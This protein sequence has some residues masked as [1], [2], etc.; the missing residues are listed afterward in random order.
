MNKFFKFI[1][2]VILLFA[3]LL[4]GCGTVTSV[5][6]SAVGPTS[7]SIAEPITQT[8]SN[9][10]GSPTSSAAVTSTSAV[11][12]V[13][14]IPVTSTATTLTSSFPV[15]TSLP[16]VPA[17]YQ[18]LYNQLQGYVTNNINQITLQWDDSTY[19]VNYSSELIT[20]DTNAGPG[21]LQSSQQQ[22]MIEELNGDAAMGVKSVTVE[23][24]CPVFD[25]NFYIFSGQTAAQAQQTVQSWLGYYQSLAQAVHN[26]GLKMI[27]ESNPLLT[28]Y[29]SSQS[30]F[31]PGLYYKTLSFAAYE[32][33]RSQHNIIIAQQIKPDYLILQTEPQTD[34]VNDFRPELNNA[35][36]D[37][38]MIKSFVNDLNN[39]GISGLHASIF[40]GSGAGTWQPDWKSYFTG[41]V[42]ISGLD[43][44]DT[45]IY[46]LQPGV[47]KIGEVTIAGQ[48][49]DMA[50]AAGKGVTMSEFWFH[51]SSTLVGLT[52]NG[53]S[54]TDL[55]V[56]DMFSFWA[57]LDAQAF[58]LLSDL[59]NYKHFDYVSAFGH[60]NW[61]A[62]IDYDSLQTVP[63][64]PPANDTQN[65]TVDDQIT[66][67]LNQAAKQALAGNW[68]STVGK[69]YQAVISGQPK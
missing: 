61:F 1:A 4:A 30:S 6:A 55:R 26:R 31:N 40:I 24:G 12:T 18:S 29:I 49:A 33:L 21:I 9:I 7:T 48:I 11:P 57:P 22:V 60:Y 17:L 41:L 20:A 36:Q 56:R 58:Q 39:A 25:P 63:V 13:T 52:E 50:H 14:S 54:L 37:V 46:N 66:T 65:A 67:I 43:K 27:V 8:T 15:T 69:A 32:Q 59:A 10:I 28:Y 16:T 45:H 47:N 38:A 53:D 23:I 44:I 51:K 68:L 5:P 19:P 64:Y 35:S 42:A 62:L 2:F 34:A 3:I